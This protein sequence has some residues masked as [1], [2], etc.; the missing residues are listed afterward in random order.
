M[1]KIVLQ[2]QTIIIDSQWVLMKP[3]RFSV[4]ICGKLRRKRYLTLAQFTSFQLKKERSRKW[5]DHMLT[6][7]EASL[8]WGYSMNQLTMVL[9][10]TVMNIFQDWMSTSSID[11]KLSKNLAKEVLV[12]FS[13]V[14]I[15]KK[16]NTVL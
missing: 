1:N 8:R 13:S 9:T 2:L 7:L 14:M 4:P 6:P 12:W 11:T 15:T 16:E 5:T 3:L 10:A